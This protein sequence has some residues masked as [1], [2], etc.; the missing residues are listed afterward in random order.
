ML[1]KIKGYKEENKTLKTIEIVVMCLLLVVSIA[2]CVIGLNKINSDDYKN[3]SYV[4]TVTLTK[5]EDSE[6]DEDATVCTITYSDG[7]DS[8]IKEYSDESE[9]SD[10]V[11]AYKYVLDNGTSL[12][13]EQENPSMNDL[14]FTYKEEMANRCAQLFNASIACVILALSVWIIYYFSKS[15]TTYEKSWFVSIM[16]LATIVAVLFPEEG[17]NGVNGIIIMLLYLLDTFLNILCELLISKKSRYN[18]LVSVVVE[19]T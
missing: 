8:L 4:G 2:T 7:E 14:A 9:V 11:E 19:I 16:L 18:F 17:A 3:A 12:C 6:C 10:T 5:D 1:E 15:F 13:F